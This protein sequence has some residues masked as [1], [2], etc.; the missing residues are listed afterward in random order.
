ME[1]ITQAGMSPSVQTWGQ[2]IDICA[3]QGD[4]ARASLAFEQMTAT[5]IQPDLTAYSSLLK[6]VRVGARAMD[7]FLLE[8]VLLVYTDHKNSKRGGG[9]GRGRLVYRRHKQTHL[10][11][12]STRRSNLECVGDEPSRACRSRHE[13]HAASSYA[14]VNVLGGIH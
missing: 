7:R 11:L 2:L 6:V 10:L 13:R 4:T 9:G 8:M 1:S 5:G 14:R 12:W 3:E